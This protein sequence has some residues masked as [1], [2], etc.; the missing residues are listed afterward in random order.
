MKNL[1]LTVLV[2]ALAGAA[3][4]Q[5]AMSPAQTADAWYKKGQAAEKAGDPA[6]AKTAYTKA[7][8]ADPR[9]AHARYSLGQLKLNSNAIA[10]KGREAKF[11]AVMVPVFQISEASLQESLEALA[12]IVTKE[13]NDEVAPNFIVQDPGGELGQRKIS[14][15]LKSMPAGG[16]LKYMLD[17][18]GAK[19]RYDEHAIVILPK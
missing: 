2:P 18:A 3:L 9:H 13:S 16:I 10:A 1:L 19:P 5:S 17:Q 8:Q 15:S 6:A 14:L 12:A 11:G 4:A 7:L